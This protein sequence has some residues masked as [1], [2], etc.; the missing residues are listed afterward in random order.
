MKEIRRTIALLVTLILLIC[1]VIPTNA[2]EITSNDYLGTIDDLSGEDISDTEQNKSRSTISFPKE[3]ESG[4]ISH[5]LLFSIT[6]KDVSNI[7]TSG[8]T[9]SFTRETLPSTAIY[10]T[11]NGTLYHPLNGA[12]DME[13][14]RFGVCYLDS[15]TGY[16]IPDY[17]KTIKTGQSAYGRFKVSST[18]DYG[19]QYYTF[20]TNIPKASYVYGDLALYY[21]AA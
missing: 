16:F 13:T 17:A 2:T 11:L 1:S 8:S 5:Y 18:L 3:F 9:K 6:A 21:S 20:V 12:A 4:G 19:K 15:S 7:L 14:I 10:L